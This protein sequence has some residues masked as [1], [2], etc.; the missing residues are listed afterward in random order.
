M[1]MI[2]DAMGALVALLKADAG[3]AL[4]VAERVYAG[5]LPRGEVDRM[6]RKAIVLQPSG[7]LGPGA[8]YLDVGPQRFDLFAYGETPF[9]ADRVRRQAYE[10][11]KRMRR[12]A[13]ANTLLYHVT[14]AGGLL[15]LR[16]PDTDWPVAFQSFSVLYAEVEVT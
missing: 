13:R 16:D 8:D 14:P 3:L 4:L 7:G 11:L 2:A 5:E 1:Y 10:V 9:E 12:Q 6:P 15:S